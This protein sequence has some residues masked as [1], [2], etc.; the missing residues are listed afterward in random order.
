MSMCVFLQVIE[1]SIWDYDVIIDQKMQ[2]ALFLW[3]DMVLI[4]LL[5]YSGISNQTRCI[6]CCNC[7]LAVRLKKMKF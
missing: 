5:I 6:A 7:V 1:G 2:A 3:L 4:L